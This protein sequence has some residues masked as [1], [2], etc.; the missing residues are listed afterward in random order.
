MSFGNHRKQW[1][2]W[3]SWPVIFLLVLLVLVLTFSVL[4]RYRVE[5]EMAARAAAA[6]AEFEALQTRKAE[7]EERVQYLRGPRGVEEE[8]RQNFDVAKPGEQVVIITG[9]RP[10]ESSTTTVPV[11]KPTPWY[12]F[13]Q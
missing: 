12:Y 10:P 7:L 8:I 1:T 3:H 4:E 2:W 5:R 11:S 13:W 9:E 6:R